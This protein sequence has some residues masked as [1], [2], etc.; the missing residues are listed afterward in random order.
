MKKYLMEALYFSNL[1]YNDN[2][3]IKDNLK[4]KKF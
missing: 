2:S 4:K 1:S 3:W